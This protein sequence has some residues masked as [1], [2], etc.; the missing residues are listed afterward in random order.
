MAQC[1]VLLALWRWSGTCEE[2]SGFSRATIK[3]FLGGLVFLWVNCIV[4]RSIHFWAGVPYQLDALVNSVLVQSAFSLLWTGTAL[5]LM[6]HAT[7]N[8]QRRNWIAGA[9]LLAVV[10]VKLFLL[11]LANSGTVERIVS[12]IGVGVGLL[13]IGYF[14]PVPPGEREEE[15]G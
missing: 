10:V 12:F 13:A 3:P 14:A 5:V 11:D 15:A 7:R 1:A 2:D 8:G 6:L 9:A 4:L